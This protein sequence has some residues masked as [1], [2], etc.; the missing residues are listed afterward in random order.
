MLNHWSLKDLKNF[1]AGYLNSNDA[2]SFLNGIL[3]FFNFSINDLKAKTLRNLLGMF[4]LNLGLP[5]DLNN[6]KLLDKLEFPNSNTKIPD[7][8]LGNIVNISSTDTLNE[9]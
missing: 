2:T 1:I 5:D 4:S 8:K 3:E 6:L 7:F 9:I